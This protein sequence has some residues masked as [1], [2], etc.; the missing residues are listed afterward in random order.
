MPVQEYNYLLII[1]D[2]R[3]NEALHV[4]ILTSLQGRK[5][6]YEVSYHNTS[7]G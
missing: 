6:R 1:S 7:P 4:V 2:T 5:A 3:G